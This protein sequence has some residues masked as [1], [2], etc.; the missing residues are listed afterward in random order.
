MFKA[1][2]KWLKKQC[3]CGNMVL[4]NI[5]KGILNNWKLTATIPPSI[6]FFFPG[7]PS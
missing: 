3:S 2:N 1:D 7:I 6:I 5:Y 4:N